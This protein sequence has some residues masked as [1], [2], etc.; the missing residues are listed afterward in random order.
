MHMED[1]IKMDFRN[2]DGCCIKWTELHA[3]QRSIFVV[4]TNLV[5]TP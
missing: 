3:N 1:N 2:I 5:I 4:T